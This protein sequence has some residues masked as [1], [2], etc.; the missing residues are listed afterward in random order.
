M[1]TDS[2][3]ASI[4]L[5]ARFMLRFRRPGGTEMVL[6]PPSTRKAVLKQINYLAASKVPLDARLSMYNEA[7]Y[8]A[9]DMP[10]SNGENT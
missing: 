6:R 9:C 7:C 3:P 8:W 2:D 1:D 10:H 5:P 4:G